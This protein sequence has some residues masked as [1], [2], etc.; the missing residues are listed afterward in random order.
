M[1]TYNKFLAEQRRPI[2]RLPRFPMAG[3]MF[4]G[5][6]PR[7]TGAGAVDRIGPATTR[8]Q[9]YRIQQINRQQQQAAR[10]KELKQSQLEFKRRAHHAALDTARGRVEDAMR[11]LLLRPT[12]TGTAGA[13]KAILAGSGA[14]VG[15]AA[16]RAYQSGTDSLADALGQ[17]PGLPGPQPAKFTDPVMEIEFGGREAQGAYAKALAQSLPVVGPTIATLTGDTAA[18]TAKGA[19]QLTGRELQALVNTPFGRRKAAEAATMTGLN[20][21]GETL[22]GMGGILGKLGYDSLKD[23]TSENYPIIAKAAGDLAAKTGSGY[24]IPNIV[25]GTTKIASNIGR[26]ISRNRESY[27]DKIKNKILSFAQGNNK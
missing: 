26:E 15:A 19:K 24:D 7:G 4:K 25:T 11:T 23:V 27:L 13:K 5:Q 10:Q 14:G 2:V 21:G 22:T 17:V 18:G 3:Q 9:Q 20:I 16:T 12:G 1:K 6:T 8:A